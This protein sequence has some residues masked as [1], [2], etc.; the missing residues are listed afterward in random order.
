MWSKSGVL[1]TCSLLLLMQ[2]DYCLRWADF[3]VDMSFTLSTPNP[4]LP[5]AYEVAGARKVKFFGSSFS[6]DA[7]DG[8]SVVVVYF[9][10]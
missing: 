8:T 5:N 4:R 10:M 1:R 6:F 2:F 3:S 9:S 7:S